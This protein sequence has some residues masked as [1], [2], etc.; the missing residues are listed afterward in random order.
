[1]AIEAPTTREGLLRVQ[2]VKFDIPFF[3][4][5]WLLIKLAVAAIPPAIIFAMIVGAVTAAVGMLFGGV[6]H[7][8]FG[9]GGRWI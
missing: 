7:G 4:L 2:V 3:Q 1:M 5:V 6:L 8:I 9:S